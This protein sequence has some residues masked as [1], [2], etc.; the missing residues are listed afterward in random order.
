SF[1][2]PSQESVSA[3]RNLFEPT[4]AA[5]PRSAAAGHHGLT[6]R[7]LGEFVDWADFDAS[8][9]ATAARGNLG[10]PFEGF[11]EIGAVENVVTGKLLFGFG[12]RPVSNKCFA[13]LHPNRRCRRRVLQRIG[14]PKNSA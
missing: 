10:G 2:C 1:G 4:R 11:V 13:V 9:G 7:A 6:V 3:R 14:C 5:I 12:K 8:I